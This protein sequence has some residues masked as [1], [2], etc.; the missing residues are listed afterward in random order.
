LLATP[1]KTLISLLEFVAEEMS[2][3]FFWRT[4]RAAAL[5]IFVAFAAITASSAELD[6]KDLHAREEIERL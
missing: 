6:K 2:G 1:S 5:L 3:H 4:L